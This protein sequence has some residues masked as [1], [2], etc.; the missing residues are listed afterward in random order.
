M[1]AA[2]LQNTASD[3]RAVYSI[4]KDVLGLFT[5]LRDVL[6]LLSDSKLFSGLS[7]SKEAAETVE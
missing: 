6:D 5:S 7:S 3:I 1:E 2:S 4:I